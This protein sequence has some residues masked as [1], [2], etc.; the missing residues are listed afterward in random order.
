M[1]DRYEVYRLTKIIYLLYLEKG[2]KIGLCKAVCKAVKYLRFNYTGLLRDNLP[3]LFQGRPM[4]QFWF[5]L[6]DTQSR[7][8]L[9]NEIYDKKPSVGC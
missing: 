8:N 3:E 2:V 1:E 5:P 4:D 9:L 6:D 7:I